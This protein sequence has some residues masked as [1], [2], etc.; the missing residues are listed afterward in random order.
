[1]KKQHTLGEMRQLFGDLIV[2]QA[3][4]A[5]PAELKLSAGLMDRVHDGADAL[6]VMRGN[7]TEQQRYVGELSYDVRL[8]LC[9]WLLD[10]NL[11]ARLIRVAYA[12]GTQV[13]R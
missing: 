13:C 9:M 1:M 8:I 11:A 12:A 6:L 7:P 3:Q 4:R 2:R 10:T 5:D